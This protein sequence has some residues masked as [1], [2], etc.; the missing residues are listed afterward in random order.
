MYK[1]GTV[2]TACEAFGSFTHL[3][4]KCDVSLKDFITEYEP[5]MIK[6]IKHGCQLSSNVLRI[7]LFNHAELTIDHINLIREIISK[8]DFGEINTNF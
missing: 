3:K 8:L 2:H 6:A 5:R 4:R 7:F 1:K